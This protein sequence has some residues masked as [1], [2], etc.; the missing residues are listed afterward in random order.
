MAFK[1]IREFQPKP[2]MVIICDH[3]NGCANSASSQVPD[4]TQPTQVA[5]CQ[6]VGQ[7][8]WK[9]GLSH[10]CPEHHVIERAN[11]SRIVVPGGLLGMAS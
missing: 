1:I 7:A 4:E 10:R 2:I 5:F 11:E 8:G 3:P 9:L 6:S